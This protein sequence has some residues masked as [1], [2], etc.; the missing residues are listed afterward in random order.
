MDFVAET[1]G[2]HAIEEKGKEEARIDGQE[3]K[4]NGEEENKFQKAIASWRGRQASK[5]NQNS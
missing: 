1:E 4:T 3:S 5:I 2:T